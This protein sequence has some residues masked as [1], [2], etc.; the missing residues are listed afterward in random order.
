MWTAGL[1]L[2]TVGFCV[3]GSSMGFFLWVIV[4]GFFSFLKDYIK[5]WLKCVFTDCDLGAVSN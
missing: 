5:S 3:S 2:S 1:H 4:W